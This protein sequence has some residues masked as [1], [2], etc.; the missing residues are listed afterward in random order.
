MIS[1]VA[2]AIDLTTHLDADLKI[3]ALTEFRAMCQAANAGRILPGRTLD[4]D[5]D[6]SKRILRARGP[7]G[8]FLADAMI[9][10]GDA[11]L[12]TRTATYRYTIRKAS[13]V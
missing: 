1:I 9:E 2:S 8:E 4:T 10:D 6:G 11:V 7:V 3:S 5:I 12:I 13:D